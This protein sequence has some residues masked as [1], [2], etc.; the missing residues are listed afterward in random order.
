M[1]EVWLSRLH[2][3]RILRL[4]RWG[5]IV[6]P[7]CLAAVAG[8]ATW[9]G[10][11]EDARRQAEVSASLLRD[12]MLR[13]VQAQDL[14]LTAADA[15]LDRA[16]LAADGGRATH[17]FLADMQER[18]ELGVGVALVSPDGDFLLS[19]RA[20]PPVGNVGPRDYLSAPYDEAPLF[21]DQL[22]IEPGGIEALVVARRRTATPLPGVW[23]AGVRIE[24]VEDF[25]GGVVNTKDSVAFVLRDDGRILLSHPDAGSGLV[26]DAQGPAMRAIAQAPSGLYDAKAAL[27]GAQRVYA[28]AQVGDT[29]LYA[30][31]GVSKRVLATQW[32]RTFSGVLGV[33]GALSL[34]GFGLAR[35]ASRSV[36]A[37]A[38]QV[39]LVFNRQLLAEANKT[40]QAR[41]MMLRELNH[42][43]KNSLQM[44]RSLVR[45]QAQRP[46]GP[47]LD[48]I[49]SRVMAIAAIHDL[50]YRSA[51]S[52]EI[53]LTCLL[54]QILASDAIVPPERRIVIERELERLTVDANVATPLALCAIELVTN[55]IKH[56]FGPEGGRIVVTLRRDGPRAVLTISDD[57]G[58]PDAPVRN[59][60]L[61]VVD[62]LIL[63]L[64]GALRVSREGG[65]RFE[66]AFAPGH[67]GDEDA[68]GPRLHEEPRAALTP[69]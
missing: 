60:G 44:I 37:E 2:S 59:S 50:L 15:A 55:A 49:V 54:E 42:R 39:A 29:S 8:G 46:E 22:R 21:V 24:T 18:M 57:G 40:A 27:D 69:A 7:L 56:A 63:Q 31:Y 14:M 12:F 64:G 5:S 68:P 28:Y 67:D 1:A 53:D 25:L 6:V 41:E 58:I 10:A 32:L 35:S 20:H 61:R 43:V 38:A 16:G 13:L 23:V 30:V 11:M 52:F 51:S 65:A 33:L 19:S 4:L 36:A 17:Q 45:L 47:D 34:T 48:A 26:L 66:I 62:A 9:R 3:A